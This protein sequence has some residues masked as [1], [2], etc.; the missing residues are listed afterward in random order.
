MV[1]TYIVWLILDF[2]ALSV[3]HFTHLGNF[4]IQL[5]MSNNARKHRLA[6]SFFHAVPSQKL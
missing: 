6:L 1:L 3:N 2:V 5:P 4:L